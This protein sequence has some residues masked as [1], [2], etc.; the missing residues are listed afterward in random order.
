MTHGSGI[1]DK[2]ENYM[3]INYNQKADPNYTKDSYGEE[4]YNYLKKDGMYPRIM[5]IRS[6][7]KLKPGQKSRFKSF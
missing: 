3:E 6:E 4:Y 1:Q 7:F 5:N 2:M